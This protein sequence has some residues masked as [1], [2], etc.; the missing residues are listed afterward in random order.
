MFFLNLDLSHLIRF[1]E[2]L[3]PEAEKAM[4]EAARRLTAETHAHIVE[5]VQQRLHSTREKYLQHLSFSQVSADTWVVELEPG[6]FFIE[7]GLEPGREMIDDLLNDAPKPGTKPDPHRPQVKKG[8]TKT[9]KD[10]SRY[11]VIPFDHSKGPTRQTAPA[12]DLTDTIKKV[13]GNNFSK[14]EMG[15]DGK[16]KKGFIKGFDIMKTPVK[17]AEGP[18]QGK[19]P[20]G[21]V[22]QGPTGIPLLQGIRVYQHPVKDK[23]GNVSTKKFIMTFRVV[24]SKMRGSGRWVHPGIEAKHFFDDAF[25]WA[26]SQWEDKIKNEVLDQLMDRL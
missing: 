3:R 15:S 5:Q 9:A 24:S 2:A 6:A 22:K 25:E 20:I 8:M 18:G 19:G 26:V 11:R 4:A 23:Q 12:Q 13:M 16:P 1:D 7:D 17:T 10:G 14:L 21:K